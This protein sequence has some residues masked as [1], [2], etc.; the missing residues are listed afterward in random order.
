MR[1]VP[2][3]A[4]LCAS[5]LAP[6]ACGLSPTD[7]RPEVTRSASGVERARIDPHA[8]AREIG[9]DAEGRCWGR[10]VTPA[11]V[12]TVT[13]QIM[14]QPAE[15]SSEGLVQS[16][17]VYR[18]VTRQRILRERRV[19]EFEAIC[20]EALTPDFSASLQRALIARGDMANSVTFAMD[21]P[22]RAAIRDLQAPAGL[23]TPILAR[24][25]AVEL[26]LVPL[27]PEEIAE[28]SRG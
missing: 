6:A 22:T 8:D 4:I 23:D 11:V 16:P 27:R 24:A 9:R 21:A 28:I 25:T 1:A 3:A 2:R 10:L 20:P 26:G 5:L 12:E 18:T 17:A 7:P 13:E 14:V 15:I 19:R